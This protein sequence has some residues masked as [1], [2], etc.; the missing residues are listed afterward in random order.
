MAITEAAAKDHDQLFP[1]HV[2][3]LADTDAEPSRSSTTSPPTTS[4]A[5]AEPM[6]KIG[7]RRHP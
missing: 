2:S 1:D 3:T 6:S 4:P 7:T 5:R